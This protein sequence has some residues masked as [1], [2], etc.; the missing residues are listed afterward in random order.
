MSDNQL[1]LTIKLSNDTR[2]TITI[3]ETSTV[4]QLK[5]KIDDEQAISADRQILIYSGKVLKD[6][7][8]LKEAKIT[9]G[10]TIHLVKSSKSSGKSYYL[11]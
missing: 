10:Q 4:K 9:T 3:D 8:I 2:Y 5:E 6:E 11:F 7:E 1:S